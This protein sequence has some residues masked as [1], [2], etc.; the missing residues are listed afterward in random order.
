V[1]TKRQQQQQQRPSPFQHNV[2]RAGT[3]REC[4]AVQHSTAQY[5]T[6]QRS[7][8]EHSAV[9]ACG[10]PDLEG[11]CKRANAQTTFRSLLYLPAPQHTGTRHTY[12][13]HRL[14]DCLTL[15]ASRSATALCARA[16][17]AASCLVSAASRSATS[18]LRAARG[19][20]GPPVRVA[21]RRICR[22]AGTVMPITRDIYKQ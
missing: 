18:V 4:S 10:C 20:S 7:A 11:R 2:K 16:S 22:Q 19:E 8:S 13:A 3:S 17:A 9:Q 12:T 21:E 14:A 15:I 1:T 5:D 6:L